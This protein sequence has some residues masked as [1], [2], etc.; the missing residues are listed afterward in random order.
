M[1]IIGIDPGYERLGIAVIEKSP[2]TNHK[3]KLLFSECFKTK[4]GQPHYERIRLLGDELNAIIQKFQPEIMAIE[5]L[6]LNTNQKTAMLVSEARGA[7]IYEAARHNLTVSEFSPPQIKSATTGDG[8][9]DKKA[10]IKMV[11]LL[12]KIDKTVKYDDEYDAIAV[13]LTCSALNKY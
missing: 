2:A 4:A 13:A 7:I 6:F 8:R 5:T 12:I 1:K 3:E 9:A 10:I 11:P